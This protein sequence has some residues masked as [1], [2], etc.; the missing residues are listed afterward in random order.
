MLG[1]VLA[2]DGDLDAVMAMVADRLAASGLRVAGAVQ[3]NTDRPDNPKCH[4]DLHILT[5]GEV[6][7]ISQNLG[8]MARG[9]R[10][11]PAGLEQAVG[12]VEAGLVAGDADVLV[13]NKFGK[14]EA[15]GRGFRQA[16]GVALGLGLPVV[17]GL[18]PGMQG[19]F[20]AF[21]GGTAEVLFPD[22]V[23]VAGWALARA[24]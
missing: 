6:I 23:A 3:V 14:A 1:V 13:V 5:G 20:D 18:R 12:Q 9:C 19:D 15:E 2:A 17:I 24:R 8:P 22:P 10:L 11:D 21:T 7:R 16:I 4:M